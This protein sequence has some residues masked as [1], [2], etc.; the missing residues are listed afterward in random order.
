MSDDKI[1]SVHDYFY[2][3]PEELIAQDP[4]SDRSSSRLMMLNRKTGEIEHHVFREIIDYLKAGDCLVINDT[5]VIPARLI[6]NREN[7]GGV[8]EL[9]LLKRLEDRQDIWEALARPG[10]KARLG[11]RI[12]FGGGELTADIIE[13]K[14][15]GNRLVRFEY[16]GIFEEVLDRLGQM[17]L[18]PYIT[19]KLEDK[20]RYQ[21]VYAKYEGSAAAPTAGLHF[22]N[23]L[24]K[25]IQDKGINIARVTLHVGLGTFRPVKADNI[26]EHKMHS[27]H[28]IVSREAANMINACKA[29]GGRII[30]VGTTSTRTLESASDETGRVIA[31]S[32]DTSIFIYPGYRFKVI[33]GLITNFHLPESTLIMLVSALAGR[34]NVLNAYK[35]AVEEKYRFFS[36]GDAMFLF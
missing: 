33:D 28:Y 21:T 18:P 26:L 1:L 7:T 30:S 16:E 25:A 34:E 22:T 32:S 5:K 14:E 9:L 23:E 11:D 29:N 2:E 3:L 27:E 17:P 36:F 12:E 20:N 15:D 6:G 35:T 24:L 19:H 8:V 10:K 31:G 4:L 13:V